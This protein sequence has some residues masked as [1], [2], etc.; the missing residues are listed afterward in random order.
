MG[1][2][3]IA[4]RGWRFDEEEVFTEDGELRPIDQLPEDTRKR[5]V[6]L[7]AI[8]GAPC[9]ACWL[10]HGD[11][12]ID[13]CAEATV[14]YGE[15]LEEVVL[16]PVHEADFLYWFRETGGCD[17]AGEPGFDDLFYEWFDDGNRA[18]EGYGGMDHLRTAPDEVPEP[19][20]QAADSDIDAVEEQLAGMDEAERE[21]VEVDL[22]DLDI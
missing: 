21:A 17:H 8:T 12:N 2:V 13:D 10:V 1:K 22:G 6:R 5:L 4:M 20:R 7:M 15:P 19:E 16:C 9:D 18:P 14:V 3:S 11:E